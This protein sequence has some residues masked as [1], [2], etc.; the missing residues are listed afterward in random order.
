M[1]RVELSRRTLLKGSGAALTGWTLLNTL[2]VWAAPAVL[3]QADAEVLP[4][5][6]QPAENPTGG[7]VTNLLEWEKLDSWITPPDQFF[8]VSHY[9]QPEVDVDTW[10]L[11]ISGLVEHPM[12]L[13]MADLLT[14]PRQEL[15]FT[16][17]C[18]GNHGF[19]WNFGLIGNAR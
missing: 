7:R 3:A 10:Q 8:S 6:D 15:D 2:P 11:E 17:E 18:S 12:T 1:D 5:M 14:W 4:W 9:G 19:D 13:T 16:I